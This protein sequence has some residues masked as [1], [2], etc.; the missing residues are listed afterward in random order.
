MRYKN[1]LQGLVVSAAI[2]CVSLSFGMDTPE[3]P[4]D[5][6]SKERHLQTQELQNLISNTDTDEV[7]E[8]NAAT[9]QTNHFRA[10]CNSQQ[11]WTFCMELC[12]TNNYFWSILFFNRLWSLYGL[13]RA[14]IVRCKDYRKS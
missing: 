14:T 2:S 7:T 3:S 13:E 10:S 4:D 6:V 12:C 1:T 5:S 8:R 11:I 9:V